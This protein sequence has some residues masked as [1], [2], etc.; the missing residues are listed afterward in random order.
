MNM[1]LADRKSLNDIGE[2]GGRGE[3]EAHPQKSCDAATFGS[4]ARSRPRGHPVR[5]R[6]AREVAT[7][8]GHHC[9]LVSAAQPED[10]VDILP[11]S[12]YSL[13]ESAVTEPA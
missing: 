6:L 2:W 11:P 12:P 1:S 4:E 5:L 10:T 9:L 7:C 8:Q 3:S 13:P